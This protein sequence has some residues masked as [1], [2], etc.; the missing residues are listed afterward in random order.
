MN[1]THETATDSMPVL[2]VAVGVIQDAAGRV[3]LAER[4]TGKPM[5]GYW[6]FPGGKIEVGENPR[7]ALG[8][9][10]HEELGIDIVDSLPWITREYRYPHTTARLHLFRV[11]QWQGEAH[12]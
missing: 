7:T 9:E 5:A 12:G 3:L 2:H 10:L 8:R 6:E 11:T 4:P 1:R